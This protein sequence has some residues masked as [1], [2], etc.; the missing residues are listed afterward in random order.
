MQ[1]YWKQRESERRPKLFRNLGI[2][3]V[4]YALLIFFTPPL[5]SAAV[6]HIPAGDVPGL[7]AAINTANQNGQQNTINLAPGTFTLTT[8]DNFDGPSSRGT[9]LPVISTNITIRGESDVTTIIQRDLNAPLFRIFRVDIAGTLTLEHVAIKGGNVFGGT[10]GGGILN[11]GVTNIVNS[12]VLKNSAGD[13]DGGGIFNL[14]GTLNIAHSFIVNNLGDVAGSGITNQAGI[15]NLTDSTVSQNF[16]SAGIVTG[17]PTT[18][19]NSTIEFNGDGRGAGG[20]DDRFATLEII[21]STIAHNDGEG[22]ANFLGTIRITNSTIADNSAAISNDG[23]TVELQNAIIAKNDQSRF[24]S[25]AIAC[26]GVISSAGNNL[27]EDPFKC[28]IQLLP[29]DLVGDPGLGNFIDD[30]APG[31]GRFPLL[32]GSQAIN[33]GNDAA[34][35][36]TDQLDTPR[37]GGCDI[38]AVEFYPIVNDLVALANITTAFDPSPVPG[39]P[40]GTFHITADFTNTSNQAIV[41]P[42]V[43]VVELTGEN[44]LLNADGGAGGVG[45]RVTPPNSATTPFEPGTNSTFEFLIGLQ[46]RE[47]FTFFVN[48]LGGPQTSNLSVSK[49]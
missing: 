20:I 8:V 29:S 24:G 48:M 27:I 41:H 30:G 2:Q 36:A 39:G 46:Q 44:L 13:A 7:I 47:P 37:N 43:E 45:A 17:G 42:F 25:P 26:Q 49:R 21:N 3:L 32:A 34:C 22:L 28:P 33:A 35:F 6:F 16:F 31:Q 15:L 11:F 4:V 9:G 14:A 23:G 18:I 1:T 19:K 38:G 10:G 12:T 40:A 5:L